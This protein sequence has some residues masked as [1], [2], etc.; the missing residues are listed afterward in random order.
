MFLNVIYLFTAITLPL[1]IGRNKRPYKLL[2]QFVRNGKKQVLKIEI[3]AAYKG[4]L[5]TD[6][7]R[8]KPCR[9]FSSL[10]FSHISRDIIV[11]SKWKSCLRNADG[12]KSF[13]FLVKV[14][15]HAG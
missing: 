5:A 15:M 9:F 12:L 2:N 7:K 4:L 3:G 14:C 10:N 11:S 6:G 1:T 8:R 13:Q